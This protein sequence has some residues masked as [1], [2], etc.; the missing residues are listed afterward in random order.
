MKKISVIVQW[1]FAGFFALL[2]L[3]TGSVASSILVL[4][5]AFLMAPI[6]PIRNALNKIKIK[7]AISTVLSVVLFFVAI[8]ISPAADS[9][10]T[11][12]PPSVTDEVLDS[13]NEHSEKESST[14][15]KETE[16]TSD[17]KSSESESSTEAIIN[18]G[19]TGSSVGTGTAK[20]VNPSSIPAY[21]N[22]PYVAINNNQPNFSSAELT[23]K[24]YEK[25]SPLDSL[26]RCGVAIA[27]CGKEIMPASGEERGSISSIKPSGWI[28]AK[29]N[30]ISGGYLWNR[31][32][33]LGWQLSAENA[34]RQNLITGTRYMN[35]NGMLPFENMVADYI[36]ETGNHV[37]FRVTPIFKGNN[38]VASG[39]QM[40]A[41][42][43]EDDGD[44]IC[45]NVYCYNVQPGITIDYATGKSSQ[46]GVSG[47]T[48]S[49]GSTDTGIVTKPT[50]KPTEKPIETKPST[51]DSMYVL[52]T[53]TKKFHYPYCHSAKKIAVHNYA[54]SNMTRDQLIASGYSPC[55]NCDP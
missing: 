24:A 4:I 51:P 26:G 49:S 12:G 38:L 33:L 6:K 1:C 37:A 43:I 15:Q 9:S 46:N 42:S 52:N 21:T 30:G 35:V 47:T 53:N 16:S 23:T 40:E 8:G 17:E 27:S 13:S 31:C 48:G 45:F 7:S 39:V 44:G 34:N 19:S 50:E 22:K 28:Q 18:G 55:G 14:I 29:Y 36:K 54:E 20:P 25:Y 5:A 10:D 41:Y 32:H 3:G 11:T 2:S